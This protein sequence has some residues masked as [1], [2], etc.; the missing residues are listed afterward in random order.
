MNRFISGKGQM[1][2]KH[3]K[4]SPIPLSNKNTDSL[5]INKTSHCPLELQK[6]GY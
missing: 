2:N 3:M 5:N 4:K 1:S 6:L